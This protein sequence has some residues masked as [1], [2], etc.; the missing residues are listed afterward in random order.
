V[1]PLDPHRPTRG[2][3]CLTGRCV[4]LVRDLIAPTRGR[5]QRPRLTVGPLRC[6]HPY[7]ASAASR[8]TASRHAA[9]NR[10]SSRS[11]SRDQPV[12]P[13]VSARISALT[14]AAVGRAVPSA[15]GGVG[16][17]QGYGAGVTTGY[18]AGQ[19]AYARQETAASAASSATCHGNVD[20]LPW[21]G[22]FGTN[23]PSPYSTRTPASRNSPTDRS[24][25]GCCT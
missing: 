7:A 24:N 1:L 6:L 2:G 15:A 12:R 23:P 13:A 3:N 20:G 9:C 21:P 4:K 11:S 17:D 10:A 19:A 14:C 8:A 25:A 5:K 16:M 22:R 18:I